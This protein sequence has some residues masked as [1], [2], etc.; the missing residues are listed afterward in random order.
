MEE[1][2]WGVLVSPCIAVLEITV[3]KAQAAFVG[4]HLSFV[5][6]YNFNIINTIFPVESGIVDSYN[7]FLLISHP[8]LT[9]IS[10]TH[11]CCWSTSSNF[12]C[13]IS[14]PM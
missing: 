3:D 5:L 10:S 11:R 9:V 8:F 14:L 13:G 12:A 2:W 6:C 7:F 4:V 1:S